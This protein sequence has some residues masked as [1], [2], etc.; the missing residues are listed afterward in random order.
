[1]YELLLAAQIKI[2][3]S[4]L[5]QVNFNDVSFG[6]I[7]SA[8]FIIAGAFSALYVIVGAIRYAISAGDQSHITAAKNTILYALIGLV[9][10]TSAFAII[11]FVISWF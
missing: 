11:Q 3:N 1:M 9:I 2:D 10:S 7:A 4:G 5:P 6:G 8:G